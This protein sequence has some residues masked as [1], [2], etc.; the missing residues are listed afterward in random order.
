MVL[1]LWTLGDQELY[2][3]SLGYNINLWWGLVMLAFGAAM[4]YFGRRGS[5]AKP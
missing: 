2:A 5:R 1:G 4:Y 3:R